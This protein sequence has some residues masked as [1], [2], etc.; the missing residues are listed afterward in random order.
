MKEAFAILIL[1]LCFSCTPP[2]R[3]IQTKNK[4]K[5]KAVPKIVAKKDSIN[6]DTIEFVS[7][8]D[9][10]DYTQLNGKKGKEEIDYINDQNND[11]SFLRGDLIAI[12]WKNDTIYIAGDGET[13]QMA[14][15]IVSAKK[16]KDG[17]VSKFRKQ[18]GK[19]LKY[20][21]SKDDELSDSYRDHLYK[22]AEYYIANS[23]KELIKLSVKNKE[24]LGYSVEKQNREGKD[25]YVLGFFTESEYKINTFQWVY[26][27]PDTDKIYEY[28]LAN[29]RLIYFP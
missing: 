20:L 4:T 16:L 11:R 6:K 10:F 3:K 23:Y 27:D 22:I 25:Y 24:N 13:L 5:L 29:D 17:N 1:T 21:L 12:E 28:D 26:I 9:N 19:E 14:Q 8:N 7:Y 2:E 15:W 18:Y